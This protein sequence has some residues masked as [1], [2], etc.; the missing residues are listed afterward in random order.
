MYVKDDLFYSLILNIPL[1]NCLVMF[2]LDIWN[3]ININW[4]NKLKQ[5]TTL[6]FY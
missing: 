4:V 1:T 2:V 5:V 3:E 6:W